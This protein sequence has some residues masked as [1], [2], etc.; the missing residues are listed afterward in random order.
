MASRTSFSR[1]ARLARLDRDRRSERSSSNAE[2]H[3]HNRA[4]HGRQFLATVPGLPLIH[5][6]PK[7]PPDIPVAKQQC[8]PLVAWSSRLH[9]PDP[10]C[11]CKRR[12]AAT[13]IDRLQC[14]QVEILLCM[15]CIFPIVVNVAIVVI[16]SLSV[17]SITQAN[18]GTRR[19]PVLNDFQQSRVNSALRIPHTPTRIIAHRSQ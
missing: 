4:N 7:L 9:L 8:P 17:A 14:S 3:S 18:F 2:A 15:Y 11:W 13:S 6:R 12:S 10:G 16:V 19:R 5:S 1:L